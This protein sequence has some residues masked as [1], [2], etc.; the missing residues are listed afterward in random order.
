MAL[1]RSYVLMDADGEPIEGERYDD[2]D[3]ALDAL[4]EYSAYWPNGDAVTVE[5]VDGSLPDPETTEAEPITVDDADVFDAIPEGNPF[6][7]VVERLRERGVD[8]PTIH[9]AMEA[10]YEPVEQACYDE[11]F[12]EIPEYEIQVVVPD[13]KATS[14]ERYET[15]SVAKPTEAEAVAWVEQKPEVR[16][17]EYVDRVGEVTVG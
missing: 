6:R 16:D 4:A 13:D 5:R 10:A 14:G 2:A 12:V 17:V 1:D 11:S 8:W 7:D 9:D 3:D 15:F